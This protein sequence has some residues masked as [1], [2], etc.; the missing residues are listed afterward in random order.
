MHNVFAQNK[1]HSMRG[2]ESEKN[3]RERIS[4]NIVYNSQNPAK[5]VKLATDKESRKKMNIWTRTTENFRSF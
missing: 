1:I 5:L 4:A 3:Q 2:K